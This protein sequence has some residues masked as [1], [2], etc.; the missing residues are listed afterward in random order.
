MVG[1]EREGE[2][3]REASDC[4]GDGN[5]TVCFSL[6]GCL[7]GLFFK[8]GVSEQRMCMQEQK[9]ERDSEGKVKEHRP[10]VLGEETRRQE[11][12]REENRKRRRL[13]EIE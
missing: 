11:E 12:E 5:C 9:A 2:R 8:Q 13:S 4:A 3:E 7:F 1:V 10:S 6:I